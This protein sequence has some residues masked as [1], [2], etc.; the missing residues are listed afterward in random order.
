MKL[1]KIALRNVLRHKA[2]SVLS[3]SAIMIGS[4]AI[5]FLFSML[6]GMKDDIATNIKTYGSGDV[7]IRGLEYDADDT[8]DSMMDPVHQSSDILAKLDSMEEVSVAVPRLQLNALFQ[9]DGV[10][11]FSSAKGFDLERERL[12]QENARARAKAGELAVLEPEDQG[13]VREVVLG[14]LPAP[15]A[16]EMLMTEE[17]AEKTGL[18]SVDTREVEDLSFVQKMTAKKTGVVPTVTTRELN[19]GDQKAT[20][21]FIVGKG[22]QAKTMKLSGIIHFALGSLNGPSFIMPLEDA[23]KVVR[24]GD[25]AS[26]I[27]VKLKPGQDPEAFAEKV[28]GVLAQMGRDDLVAKSWTKLKTMYSFIEM[29]EA[30]YSVI[31]GMF[32]LIGSVVIVNTTIMVILE[33]MKEIG[34][35]GAMGFQGKQLVSLFFLEALYISVVGALGGVLVGLTVSGIMSAVGLNFGGAMEGIDMDVSTVIYPRITAMSTLGVFIYSV[36]VAAL[37][38]F[39]PS[40]KAARIKPVEAL[41][42]V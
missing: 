28:N 21:F 37:A 6:A 9:V 14:R 33:R 10:D 24:K 1:Y 13:L 15:G 26:E 20:A 12:F 42:S 17:I 16:G 41:R 5:V 7:R 32:F 36:T 38:T 40:L 22:M 25:V 2:R 4:M 35:L 31:A 23:R 3:A 27:L 29:A 39:I 11:Y 30:I 8:I 34:T 19:E 18:L